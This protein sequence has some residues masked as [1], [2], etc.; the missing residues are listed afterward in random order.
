MLIALFVIQDVVEDEMIAVNKSEFK[1]RCEKTGLR[2]FRPAPT[3]T[4]LYIHRSC[5][6]ARNFGF[7]K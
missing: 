4:G 7:R 2:G 3:Q 1:P 5:L 6:E